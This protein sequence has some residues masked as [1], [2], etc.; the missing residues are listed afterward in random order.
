MLQHN[1]WYQRQRLVCVQSAVSHFTAFRRTWTICWRSSFTALKTARKSAWAKIIHHR[2]TLGFN[3]IQ[4]DFVFYHRIT[5]SELSVLIMLHSLLSAPAWTYC[6]TPCF[7]Y[8]LIYKL[9][10]HTHVHLLRNSSFQDTV[11]LI[12]SIIQGCK[13]GI[14]VTGILLSAL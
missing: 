10:R 13:I 8:S 2:K 11:V 4:S 14:N 5:V 7:T 6:T 3:L 9:Y 1:F 12:V